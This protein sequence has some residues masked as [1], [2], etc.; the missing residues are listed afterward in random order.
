METR[1]TIGELVGWRCWEYRKNGFL[2]S[3]VY[4][5]LWHPNEI[6]VTA[7]HNHPKDSGGFH[8]YKTL[9]GCDEWASRSCAPGMTVYEPLL[10]GSIYIWG[11]VIEHENGYRA[12][13]C[14]IRTLNLALDNW[15]KDPGLLK[16]VRNQY[17]LGGTPRSH[18]NTVHS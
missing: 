2:E 4:V 16:R 6:M 1:F 11:T 12:T 18:D 17:D 10:V 13:H 9:K 15:K 7:L 3:L 8:C 5:T 14:K